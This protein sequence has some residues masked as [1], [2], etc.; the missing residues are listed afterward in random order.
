VL[1]ATH[2]VD[3]GSA[4][5]P[6]ASPLS[7]PTS[8]L[9]EEVTLRARSSPRT[10]SHTRP[11][12][13]WVPSTAAAPTSAMASRDGHHPGLAPLRAQQP[14]SFPVDSRVGQSPGRRGTRR[15][16][17]HPAPP[18]FSPRHFIEHLGSP[19]LFKLVFVHRR[20]HAGVATTYPPGSAA[21]RPIPSRPHAGPHRAEPHGSL[22]GSHAAANG[23]P[24]TRGPREG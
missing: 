17:G 22:T 8:P 6:A 11:A 23:G 1:A 19:W 10:P 24:A 20:P 14:R 5:I 12:P 13:V 2:G 15:P 4:A 16:R 3:P 7:R 21:A 18:S 9:A